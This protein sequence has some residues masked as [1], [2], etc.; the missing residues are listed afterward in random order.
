MLEKRTKDFCKQYGCAP[1]FEREIQE[2]VHEDMHASMGWY[3]APSPEPR[4]RAGN[5]LS[6]PT[7][8][9]PTPS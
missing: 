8:H 5:V 3:A 9:L 4:A 1:S 2:M 6:R 7:P